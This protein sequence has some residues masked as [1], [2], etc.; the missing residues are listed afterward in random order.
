MF[1]FYTREINNT[2][3]IYKVFGVRVLKLKN[4]ESKASAI[5]Q[6]SFDL[7]D[8][9]MSEKLII[10]LIPP[11]TEIIGGVMS[12]FSLCEH[13][14]KLNPDFHCLIATLPGKR[15]VAINDNF[16]NNERI[17]RFEQIVNNALNAKQVIIHIPEYFAGI[18]YSKLDK[19]EIEFLKNI[20]DL[21][22]N[23]L[24]QNIN[25]MPE[26]ISDLFKI[27]NNVTQTV[28]HKRYAT[29]NF[30]NKWGI[31]LH[32]VAVDINLRD[33]KIY[34]FEEKEKII[35]YSNDN[36]IYKQKIL[37]KLLERFS[38][39]KFVEVHN[40]TFGKYMDIIARAY[41]VISFGEGMDGYFI[42]PAYVGSIGISVYNSDFFPDESWKNF[43][44]VY[45]SYDTMLDNI[46]ADLNSMVTNKDLYYDIIKEQREKF[47][48]IYNINEFVRNLG[49]FYSKDYD[50]RE[51]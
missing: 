29:Q 21:Q 11:T 37:S 42:Q 46:C 16:K 14:R 22:I 28:A 2:H 49:R 50:F 38:D 40:M 17:F 51:K 8:I 27:T 20:N 13:S 23:I 5:V 39:W 32:Y 41:A 48:E 18:F 47:D 33:Y 4:D 34:P 19:S 44:N 30:Y 9:R 15:T 7:T 1:K 45:E 6:N 25:N 12:A 24:N 36:N 31:P 10:F 35:V 26:D 3:T 43:K